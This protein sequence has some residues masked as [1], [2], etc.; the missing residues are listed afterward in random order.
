MRASVIC[1]IFNSGVGGR[2]GTVICG[3]RDEPLFLPRCDSLD[4]IYF[5]NNYASSALHEIA[6]WCLAGAARRKIIDYGYWYKEKRTA[7]EQLQFES[8]E[9]R[10]QA[11]EWIF[12]EAA[13]VR[14]RVSLDNFER[15]SGDCFE[16][17]A[18]V[19]EEA[20]NLAHLVNKRASLFLSDLLSVTGNKKVFLPETFE[21]IP[22][23]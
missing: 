5:T 12:S 18:S 8:L 21:E 4:E 3:G 1:E 17:R 14:F 13:G 2:Y 11:L 9:I 20:R 22:G 23:C 10:P 16:F 7:E 6:H 19:R 15:M